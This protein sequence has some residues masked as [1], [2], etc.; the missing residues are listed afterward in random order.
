MEAYLRKDGKEVHRSLEKVL[1]LFPV[2]KDKLHAKGRELS[3]GQQR[4][5]LSHA[6]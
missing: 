2:L 6:V 4:C 3:G 5:L 1:A